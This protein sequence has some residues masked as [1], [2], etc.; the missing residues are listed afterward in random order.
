M[1]DDGHVRNVSPAEADPAGRQQMERALDGTAR[2]AGASV[3]LLYLPGSHGHVLYL[4]TACGVSRELTATWSR[5]GWEE[6]IP[7]ADA[8]REDRLVWLGGPEETARR[9][10]RLGLVVPYDFSLAAAPIPHEGTRALGGVV[11][12]WPGS[13]PPHLAPRERHVIGRGAYAWGTSCAGPR[14]RPTDPPA[15]PPR[16][17]APSATTDP[18][19]RRGRLGAGLRPPASRRKLCTRPEWKDHLRHRRGGRSARLLRTRPPRRPALGRIAYGHAAGGPLPGGCGD[20]PP[21]AHGAGTARGLAAV[22]PLRPLQRARAQPAAPKQGRGSTAKRPASNGD[23]RWRLRGAKATA[24]PGLDQQVAAGVLGRGL[25][26]RLRGPAPRVR[27]PRPEARR[28]PSHL[29]HGTWL[30]RALSSVRLVSGPRAPER[31]RA[32]AR[33]PWA[34]TGRSMSKAVSTVQSFPPPPGRNS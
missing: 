25:Q 13:H 16:G 12:L 10:P 3:G 26:P 15:C 20:Q 28:H 24:P 31:Q 21:A 29:E 11:L 8:V 33:D 22:G 18:G 23:G 2:A 9:Y 34:Q 5:V 7:V 14:K 30:A 17:P 19:T 27:R 6:P 32:S 4:A 1:G